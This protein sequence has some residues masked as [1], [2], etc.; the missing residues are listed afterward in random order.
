V[1]KL[2]NLK[3]IDVDT[4]NNKEM[5]LLLNSMEYMNKVYNWSVCRNGLYY[6]ITEKMMVQFDSVTYSYHGQAAAESILVKPGSND[7]HYYFLNPTTMFILYTDRMPHEESIYF[8]YIHQYNKKRNTYDNLYIRCT[9]QELRDTLALMFPTTMIETRNTIDIFFYN[10][11]HSKFFNEY[12]QKIKKALQN[13][14]KYFGFEIK[15]SGAKFKII[16]NNTSK[17]LYPILSISKNITLMAIIID[18]FQYM[19]PIN[20]INLS[21]KEISVIEGNHGMRE[22]SED[23]LENTAQYFDANDL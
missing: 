8:N 4:F 13:Q 6:L 5:Y 2:R 1:L 22:T 18:L 3:N 11:T 21:Y 20:I 19:S 9:F 12:N 23:E 10:T 16:A 17:K 7:K 14:I 15:D